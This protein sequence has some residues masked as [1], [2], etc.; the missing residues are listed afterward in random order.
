MIMDT[1]SHGDN[2]NPEYLELISNSTLHPNYVN[3]TSPGESSDT[4][5]LAPTSNPTLRPDY[6]NVTNRGVERSDPVYH[7][8]NY[9]NDVDNPEIYDLIE[10]EQPEAAQYTPLQFN[11]TRFVRIVNFLN[12]PPSRLHYE[13]LGETCFFPLTQKSFPFMPFSS[14]PPVL[15]FESIPN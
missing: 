7:G 9:E 11:Q 3:A 10:E 6:V 15:D 12:D 1:T 5:Y 14:L 2:L 8:L 4:D 13:S